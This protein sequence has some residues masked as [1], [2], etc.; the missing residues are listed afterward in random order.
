MKKPQAALT[1]LLPVNEVLGIVL[2]VTHMALMAFVFTSGKILDGEVHAIQIMFLRYTSA[3]VLL[4]VIVWCRGNLRAHRT[5]QLSR[6][7]LRA[8]FGA[9]GTVTGI[10][11][12]IHMP[13]ADAAAIGMLKGMLIVVFAVII[14]GEVVSGRQW[15]AALL[16]AAGACVIVWGRGASLSMSG[17]GWAATVAFISAVGTALELISVR[18]LALRERPFTLTLYVSGIGALLLAIP[19]WMVWT[20]LSWKVWL[21]LLSLG[22]LAALAQTINAYAYGMA[23]ASLLAPATYANI[24]LAAMWGYLLFGEVPGATTW[25]GAVLIIAGGVWLAR[26]GQRSPAR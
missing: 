16:C 7:V 4:L 24:V 2:T 22:P 6:H 19:A 21:F 13:V 9:I 20:S 1:P 18:Y 10:Y 11:A 3:F 12:M 5:T 26:L 17:Y 8:C 25:A 23:R 15:L 14:L